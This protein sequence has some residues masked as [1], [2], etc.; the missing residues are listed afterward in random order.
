MA[1]TLQDILRMMSNPSQNIM[2]EGDMLKAAKSGAELANMQ[3][4]QRTRM[5]QNPMEAILSLPANEMQRNYADGQMPLY[6][7]GLLQNPQGNMIDPQQLMNVA[8]DMNAPREMRINAIERLR[9][10]GVQ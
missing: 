10:L 1:L 9:A 7:G 8:Y 6:A 4:N 5:A 3:Q 2:A